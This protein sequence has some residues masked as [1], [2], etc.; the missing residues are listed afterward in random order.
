MSLISLF[1]RHK[2]AANLLMLFIII[3]G[4]WSLRQLNV[5]FLPT[6]NILEVNIDV[7]WRGASAEDV[8]RLVTLPIEQELNDL[9]Y[10]DEIRSTSALG[11]ASITVEFEQGTDMGE[12]TERVRESVNQA[13]GDLPEDSEQPTVVRVENFERVS[14]LLI[15]TLGN[16]DELR[17]LVRQYER[18]LLD[19][20]IAKVSVQG[21]PEERMT[22]SVS[23]ARIAELNV[24]LPTIAKRIAALS[25]DVPAGTIG[26]GEVGRQIRSLDKQ[27][28]ILGF[29]QLPLFS[30][31]NGR[32]IRLGDIATIS[33]EPFEQEPQVF[34]KGLPA[35]IMTL[36]RTA[37]A[38]SLKSAEIIQ[39]W[40]AE[41]TPT[42]PAGMTIKE[43]DASWELIKGRINLLLGNGVQ[44]LILILGLLFF[45]LNARV[46]FWVA[47][48]IP[49]SFLAAMFVL[50]MAG[51]SI[52]MVT[53]FAMIMTLGIIV[54]DTIVVGEE[55]LTQIQRGEPYLTACELGA[56]RMFVPV[57]ASS[58]TTITAFMPLMMIGDIIGTILFSIPLVV[59]SVILAS[60]LEG[61]LVLPGHLYHSFRRNGKT[62]ISKFRHT[63]DQ[64][65]EKFKHK[66]FR[67]LIVKAVEMPMTALAIAVGFL[68]INVGV[69]AAGWINFNF[70]PTPDGN[71]IYAD[72]QFVSGTSQKEKNAFMVQLETALDK[73]VAFYAESDPD[74]VQL[75][76]R[77]DNLL[78]LNNTQGEQYAALMV[79]L[80][81]TDK[82]SV[83]NIELSERW[84]SYVGDLPNIEAL[85]IQAPRAGPPGKDIDIVLSGGNNQQLKAASNEL[86]TILANYTGVSNIKDDM[87]YGQE[88]LIFKLN[89]Q[90]RALNLTAGD[91]GEQIRAAYTGALAQTF[92]EGED[93][94]DV[95]VIL[96]AQE[97]DSIFSL[98]RLPLVTPEGETVLLSTVVDLI[99]QTGVDVLR[100]TDTK[101]TVH[102]TAE[103]D[104]NVANSNKILS[105]LMSD[106]LPKL[107][108]KHGLKYRLAGRS[109]E[110]AKT[111]T[112]MKYGLFVAL[113]LIY[114]VLAWV[115]ASYGW[116]IAVMAAIPIGLSGAI[117]GHIVMG[118]DITILSLF[119][120]FGLAGIV[121][122]DS[123]ILIMRFKECLQEGL[124]TAHAL[125]EASMQ[126]FRAVLLTSLTTIAGL[127]PLLFERSLQAQF[128][129]PM[130]VSITFGLAFGTL[131]ILVV[132][133][134]S[135]MLY[136][137][138][139][140]IV[141][142]S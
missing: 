40:I 33:R 96:P 84:R 10:V 16:L 125:V 132:V 94:I 103:V 118:I 138:F 68:L 76:V 135:L 64:R 15:T 72:V 53:L 74:L 114:I 11:H 34:Y 23:M 105:Q 117:F 56:K 35:V 54:D 60:L 140:G 134:A 44:G 50:L 136:E 71:T 24:S 20:G 131:L 58:L 55:T 80:K 6:I 122:N 85:T 108:K 32:L 75:S 14:R 9:D 89:A 119:G 139:F 120:F 28:S 133:P 61:F 102:V 97:R 7:V 42:L 69:V 95:R 59:V 63:V 137:R 86:Q 83:T 123:I 141:Q 87:P 13:I 26:R 45:F 124:D 52:N 110:Q 130:A 126:R 19:A 127:T 67:P 106:S 79:E 48:G 41:K 112:D 107:S 37:S 49:I 27:R 3:V 51:D 116:P 111:L 91:V 8:E 88:Q 90:G 65:F 29:E 121:I 113:A 4:F 31:D 77:F 128:L 2:V 104:P 43:F 100:H 5:Q 18:E 30:D 25:Q 46:A 81:E 47:V 17:P 82:R 39:N 92:F 142:E 57:L 109:E 78:P 12:A 101:L 73:T 99:P 21:L 93:E 66:Y 1:V 115:F 36:Q 129:I 22:V 98:E 38:N 70:F 62:T